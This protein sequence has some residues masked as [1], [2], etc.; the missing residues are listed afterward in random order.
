MIFAYSMIKNIDL[1]LIKFSAHCSLWWSLAIKTRTSSIIW[2]MLKKKDV[3]QFVESSIFLRKLAA[4]S[5]KTNF[6]SRSSCKSFYIERCALTCEMKK[7]KSREKNKQP[8][9]SSYFTCSLMI[10]SRISN[11]LLLLKLV[12]RCFPLR[13][14][15]NIIIPILFPARVRTHIHLHLNACSLYINY[16]GA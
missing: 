13:L 1:Y 15:K 14:T 10:M 12:Y 9:I 8:L 16:I 2:Q 7:K 4:A 11:L 6:L 3:H 5:C